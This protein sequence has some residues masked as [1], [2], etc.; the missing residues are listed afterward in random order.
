MKY[1]IVNDKKTGKRFLLDIIE[2]SPSVLNQI[3]YG[4]PPK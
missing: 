3:L 1:N 4:K 2:D